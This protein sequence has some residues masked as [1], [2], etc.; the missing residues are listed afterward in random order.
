MNYTLILLPLLFGI[1]YM[2][3]TKRNAHKRINCTPMHRH[4]V[5]LIITITLFTIVYSVIDLYH[6]W[7]FNSK[8][9][10]K[11]MMALQ[12]G[13]GMPYAYLIKKENICPWWRWVLWSFVVID[14]ELRARLAEFND[15]ILLTS[16]TQTWRTQK[17]HFSK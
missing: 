8:N 11:R 15:V 13:G 2:Y 3:L 1:W 6:R 9:S 16:S 14:K 4:N 7:L 5:K 12:M 10:I 17:I